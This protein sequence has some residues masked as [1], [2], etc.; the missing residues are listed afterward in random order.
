MAAA[1]VV[2]VAVMA[3]GSFVREWT[4]AVAA[5][6]EAV[7]VV[8]VWEAGRVRRVLGSR[9][10]RQWMRR[11]GRWS[12]TT[13]MTALPALEWQ[14]TLVTGLAVGSWRCSS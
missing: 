9:W 10:G 11:C 8:V 4:V 14:V 1:A 5:A 3:V 13:M 2:A 12:W 7:V 6:T